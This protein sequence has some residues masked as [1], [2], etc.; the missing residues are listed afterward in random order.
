MEM[1]LARSSR[2][3]T[4][5]ALPVAEAERAAALGPP[6]EK[7]VVA[8]SFYHPNIYSEEFTVFG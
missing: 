8:I 2:S 4:L 6:E 3:E 5:P 1:R 7:V